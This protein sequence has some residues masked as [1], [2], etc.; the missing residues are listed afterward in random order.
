LEEDWNKL[1]D[2]FRHEKAY[3]LEETKVLWHNKIVL[4]HPTGLS[5]DISILHEYK[6]TMGV[7]VFLAFDKSGIRNGSFLWKT[8]TRVNFD[9]KNVLPLKETSTKYGKVY[10]PNKED[11]LLE[12]WYGDWQTPVEY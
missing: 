8:P 2:I 3:K 10:F 5:S 6:N 4:K 7:N 11:K 9:K 1:L 12:Y